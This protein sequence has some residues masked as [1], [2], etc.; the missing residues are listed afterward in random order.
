MN[1]SYLSPYHAGMM[2]TAFAVASATSIAPINS[3]EAI[4][5]TNEPKVAASL[6]ILEN[7]YKQNIAPDITNAATGDQSEE[8]IKGMIIPNVSAIA[9]RIR[10]LVILTCVVVS[11]VSKDTN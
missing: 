7:R 11:T 6:S 3:I 1:F 9:K 10:T 2:S 5:D 8:I 4:R